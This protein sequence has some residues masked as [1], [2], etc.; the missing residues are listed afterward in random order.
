MG[1]GKVGPTP[2]R[3]ERQRHVPPKY[4]R[5]TIIHTEQR[6]PP[7]QHGVPT[8][9][10]RLPRGKSSSRDFNSV[11]W[12]HNRKCRPLRTSEHPIGYH[13]SRASGAPSYWSLFG[14]AL[15]LA[16]VHRGLTE[17]FLNLNGFMIIQETNI[18]DTNT[19][20]A[21][22]SYG[23]K[24]YMVLFKICQKNS[25]NSFLNKS[26]HPLKMTIVHLYQNDLNKGVWH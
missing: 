15:V 13:C 25:Q 26:K 12:P 11:T 9:R 24:I 19:L 17:R 18:T 23:G 7:L 4:Q 3:T 22:F 1:R 14:Y 10:L 2:Q 5:T 20:Q 8:P 16:S 21:C 6:H